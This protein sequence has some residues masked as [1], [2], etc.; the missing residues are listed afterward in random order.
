MSSQISKGCHPDELYFVHCIGP[1]FSM[2]QNGCQIPSDQQLILYQ[3]WF[4]TFNV[5]KYQ[6]VYI[7]WSVLAHRKFHPIGDVFVTNCFEKVS[8][9]KLEYWIQPFL[10]HVKW[11]HQ[12]V[13]CHIGPGHLLLHLQFSLFQELHFQI[14]YH[15]GSVAL[16]WLLNLIWGR[17]I[18][19]IILKLYFEW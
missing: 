5:N 7:W 16:L 15:N 13:F 2:H 3:I 4:L 19:D 11:N 12:N 14:H 18:V 1:E 8:F 9:L 10:N 6:S 17:R